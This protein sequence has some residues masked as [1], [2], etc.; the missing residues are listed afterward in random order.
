[1]MIRLSGGQPPGRPID[2]PGVGCPKGVFG[3]FSYYE[4][5]MLFLNMVC[6]TVALTYRDKKMEGEKVVYLRVGAMIKVDSMIMRT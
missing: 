1:M 4:L 5:V 3:V 6:L 2:R